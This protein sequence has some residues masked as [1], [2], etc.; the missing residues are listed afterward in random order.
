VQ[1]GG[2]GK[3]VEPLFGQGLQVI[4][5]I[6]HVARAV[7]KPRKRF[8]AVGD[9]P[10]NQLVKGSL[11]FRPAKVMRIALKREAPA[12]VPMNQTVGAPAQRLARGL[13]ILGQRRRVRAGK[14]VRG[15]RQPEE[16][17]KLSRGE[18]GYALPNYCVL[19]FRDKRISAV[20][21]PGSRGQGC[22]FGKLVRQYGVPGS[23]RL[24]V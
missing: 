18:A 13:R 9:E 20:Q 19:V 3:R 12:A 21:S 7:G 10:E 8:F 1:V 5:L 4:G 24:A 14:L 15:Q 16:R 17:R 11:S 23:E 6:E 22:G 2:G